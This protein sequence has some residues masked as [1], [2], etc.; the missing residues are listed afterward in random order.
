MPEPRRRDDERVVA[1][2]AL[3]QLCEHQPGLNGLAEA[4]FVG[5]QKSRAGAARDGECGL[6]LKW[7]KVDVRVER[8]AKF[9]ESA[10]SGAERMK[11][12]HP[13]ARRCCADAW[14]AADDDR[15]VEW[16]EQL[17]APRRAG[18]V[19]RG[20]TEECRVSERRRLLNDPSFAPH[21]DAVAWNDMHAWPV[22]N[23]HTAEKITCRVRFSAGLRELSTTLRFQDG[24][25]CAQ[26]RGRVV[27]KLQHQRVSLER[28]LDD[29]A[30]DAPAAAMHETH[31]AKARGVCFIQILFDDR[32]DVTW[33]E[34]MQIE[35][36]VDG[37]A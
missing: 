34:G 7:K 32:R 20:E 2:A 26:M 19:R 33:R 18:F 36:V 6:E 24:N 16:C 8:R 37:N 28:L 3:L 25:C 29:A 22:R 30:L 12:I 10:P 5:Q 27:E 14:S 23:A 35:D 4:H 17:A 31:V 9:P 13:A 1:P 15:P 21:H 11:V